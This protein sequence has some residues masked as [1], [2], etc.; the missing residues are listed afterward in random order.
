MRKDKDFLYKLQSW[1]QDYDKENS[2]QFLSTDFY[3]LT[4][5]YK[6]FMEHT[7]NI[8]YYGFLQRM[9]PIESKKRTNFLRRIASS[10]MKYA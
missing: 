9:P 2:N 6:I 4:E 3:G 1:A 10:I 7:K 8:P 5:N